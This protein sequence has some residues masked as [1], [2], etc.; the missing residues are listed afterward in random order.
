[1]VKIGIEFEMCIYYSRDNDKGIMTFLRELKKYGVIMEDGSLSPNYENLRKNPMLHSHCLEFATSPIKL[2]GVEK[3]KI[4]ED[5]I[6]NI[7]IPILNKIFFNHNFKIY[8]NEGYELIKSNSDSI[9]IEFNKSTGTHIHYSNKMIKKGGL[10]QTIEDNIFY[11]EKII[12]KMYQFIR[13]NT[14]YETIRKDYY[15]KYTNSRNIYERYRTINVSNSKSHGTIEFRLFN[16]H[17]ITTN[18]FKNA[19]I[20]QVELMLK[21]IDLGFKIVDKTLEKYIEG[22]VKQRNRDDKVYNY[23]E[24]III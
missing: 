15:R 24:N 3:D 17:G 10:R 12:S 18:D 14:K 9:I 1:M 5:N 23:T 8:I 19:L 16:L 21:S 11:D 6:R 2:N 22:R 7:L 4:N 13:K 20:H